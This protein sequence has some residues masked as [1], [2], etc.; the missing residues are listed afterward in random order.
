MAIVPDKSGN[1]PTDLKY[2]YASRTIA[3]D[4]NIVGPLVPAFAGEIVEDTTNHA[5]WKATGTTATSWVALTP[6][7]AT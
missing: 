3:G 1:N 2:T 6:P 7:Y 4:P 5:L